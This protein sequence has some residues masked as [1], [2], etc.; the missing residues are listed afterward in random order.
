[1]TGPKSDSVPYVLLREPS[2]QLH[3]SSSSSSSREG[4]EAE[5][6]HERLQEALPEG[7][8]WKRESNTVPSAAVHL[9]WTCPFAGNDRAS[10]PRLPICCADQPTRR[11]PYC[12][13][14]GLTR[15][16]Q[17]AYCSPGQSRGGFVCS[18]KEADT[19]S[20]PGQSAPPRIRSKTPR[21]AKSLN[22]GRKGR[23]APLQF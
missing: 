17:G 19:R 10:D 8:F 4:Q 1:M 3:S 20:I 2:I 13:T 23:R 6:K 21:V 11:G 16:L 12:R 14:N 22:D 5:N 18:C 7:R 9:C 15:V